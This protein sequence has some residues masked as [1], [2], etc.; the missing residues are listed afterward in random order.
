MI[1]LIEVSI[2]TDNSI[3]SMDKD[4]R[5]FHHIGLSIITPFV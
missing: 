4:N 3:A 5:Y 2:D 1:I